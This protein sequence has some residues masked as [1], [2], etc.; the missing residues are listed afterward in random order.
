M[1]TKAK[2]SIKFINNELFICKRF[3]NNS[4]FKYGEKAE[5]K[6]EFVDMLRLKNIKKILR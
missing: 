4:N 2:I 6:L 5:L 1:R 3:V